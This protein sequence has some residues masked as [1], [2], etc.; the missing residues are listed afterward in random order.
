MC[1]HRVGIDSCHTNLKRSVV[2]F[3]N[4]RAGHLWHLGLL[5]PGHVPV[6]VTADLDSPCFSFSRQGLLQ[7]WLALSSVRSQEC[8]FFFHAPPLPPASR[9]PSAEFVEPGLVYVMLGM[10]PSPHAG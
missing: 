4:Q 5:L 6:N 1:R 2:P 10:G 8:L 3:A 7:L 9:L